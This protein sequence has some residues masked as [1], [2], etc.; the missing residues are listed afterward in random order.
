VSEVNLS[1][2]EYAQMFDLSPHAVRN[3]VTAGELKAEKWGNKWMIQ[4]DETEVPLKPDL[5]PLNT[6]LIEKL[7]H[8]ISDLQSTI[9]D[10]RANLEKKED[11]LLRQENRI[12]ELIKQ[13]DQSQ[14]IIMSMEKDRQLL[15][16]SRRS[17]FS[18][19]L[20]FIGVGS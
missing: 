9:E 14:V 10:L 12:D 5:N 11:E 3:Q 2:T 19:L 20:N 17:P 15:V 4:I 1:I 8:H 6:D 16:E 18:K 7:E 13:Q